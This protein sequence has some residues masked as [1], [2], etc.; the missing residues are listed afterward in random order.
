MVL[1]VAL[2]TLAISHWA[3]SFRSRAVRNELKRTKGLLAGYRFKQGELTIDESNAHEL[4]AIAIRRPLER[5][6]SGF[7]WRIHVPP[8]VTAILSCSST[9]RDARGPLPAAER[10]KLLDLSEGENLAHVSFDKMIGPDGEDKGWY[11]SAW[12]TAGYRIRVSGGKLGPVTSPMIYM[13]PLKNCDWLGKAIEELNY[14]QTGFLNQWSTTL[15]SPKRLLQ[16][17]QHRDGPEVNIWVEATN[18]EKRQQQQF[19]GDGPGSKPDDTSG[20]LPRRDKYSD[21]GH[22][23]DDEGRFKIEGLVPGVTYSLGVGDWGART[24]ASIVQDMILQPGEARDAGDVRL[25]DLEVLRKRL[26]MDSE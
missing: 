3:L 4:N 25:E 21:M 5:S 23:T 18:S 20:P 10:I 24:F 2:A 14:D 1:L 9:P 8:G 19:G 26:G 22:R 15:N 12:R 6:G 11:V 7:E 16:F 13:Q 17:Y